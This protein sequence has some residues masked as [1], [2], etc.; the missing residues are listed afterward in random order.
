MHR[1]SSPAR[2]QP[3]PATGLWWAPATTGQR[4]RTQLH[5]TWLVSSHRFTGPAP[6]VDSASV[7][8]PQLHITPTQDANQRPSGGVPGLGQSVAVA[9]APAG[10]WSA[11]LRSDRLP[12]LLLAKDRAMTAA[13]SLA[14]RADALE[15]RMME[16]LDV[17]V[18]KS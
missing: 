18:T 12:V 8:R 16:E 10:P 2:R 5:W 3:T 17:V 4:A 15:H 13:M 14:E 7:V 1:A 11:G 9:V 6:F